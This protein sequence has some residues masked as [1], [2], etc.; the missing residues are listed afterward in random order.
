VELNAGKEVGKLYPNFA[1]E[2]GFGA[3]T[4]DK[5]THGWWGQSKAFDV[6]STTGTGWVK[7]VAKG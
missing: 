7:R 2:R 6:A 3:S 1:R 4:D 5:D